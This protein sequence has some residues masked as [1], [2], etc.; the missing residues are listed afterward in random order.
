MSEENW[1]NRAQTAEAT[2]ATARQASEAAI[3]RIREFKSNFGVRD[4]ADGSIEIDYDKFVSHL[5]L[6][7]WLQL[8]AVGDEK[9][10]VSGQIGNKPRVRVNGS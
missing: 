6:D 2:L 9:Y 1:I 4:R 5:G 8:R 10:R 7:G 3:A